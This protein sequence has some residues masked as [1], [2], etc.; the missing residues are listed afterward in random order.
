MFQKGT[1]N[2]IKKYR[3]FMFSLFTDTDGYEYDICI[4]FIFYATHANF[5]LRFIIAQYY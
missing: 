1:E 2:I 5:V 4:A 3:Y